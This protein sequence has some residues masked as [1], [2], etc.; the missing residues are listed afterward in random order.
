MGQE[1]ASD[2]KEKGISTLRSLARINQP[3]RTEDF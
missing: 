1:L 3:W 2:I